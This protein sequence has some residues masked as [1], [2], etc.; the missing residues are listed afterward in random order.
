M[1]KFFTNDF[2]G[3]ILTYLSQDKALSIFAEDGE[4]MEFF[5]LESSEK[6]ISWS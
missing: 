3:V 6:V 2:I 5:T 1:I 4:K